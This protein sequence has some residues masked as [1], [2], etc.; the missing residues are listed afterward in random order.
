MMAATAAVL[1]LLWTTVTAQRDCSHVPH[2]VRLAIG[3]DDTMTVSFAS[4]WSDQ[5]AAP[6]GGVV[7]GTQLFVEQ[8]SPRSY[9]FT[10]LY[11]GEEPDPYASAYYHH[12]T[13][14][15]LDPDTEY[16][17]RP[18]FAATREE[19]TA[20]VDSGVMG[21]LEKEREKE[22][23]EN[24][25]ENS[26]HRSLFDQHGYNSK[27]QACPAAN[28]FRTF[29]TAPASIAAT[30]GVLGDIG[31]TKTAEQTLA[32]LVGSDLDFLLFAGDLCYC[33]GYAPFWDIFLDLMDDYPIGV[34]FMTVPGNHDIDKTEEGTEIFL[35]Y[36]HRFRMPQ[37]RPAELGVGP[38][39]EIDRN[40]VPYPLP[41]EWGNSYYSF[42]Y[43]G[44]FN[45]MLNVYAAM[46]P[47]SQQY[48]WLKT[49]LKKVNRTETPWLLVTMHVPLYNTFR[50]H[51]HDEQIL[52]ARKHLKP[53][54]ER[55]H[56]NVVF[57]GHLH[58]YQRTHALVH[59]A[60]NATGPMYITVG[61]GG[62]RESK[63][64]FWREEPEEWV[65]VRDSTFYGFGIL[66]IL[67]A[68]TAQWEW[69]HTGQEEE[70]P[71]NTVWNSSTTLP[72]GPSR[73]RL[74]LYNHA[75]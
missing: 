29:R 68:K 59:G 55:Y 15:G 44:T 30:I 31:R 38:V 1:L 70:H 64:D 32:R 62:G 37:V 17:Y 4:T 72:K 28:E 20:L 23:M 18:V 26:Q 27:S 57:S 40:E 16:S 5:K 24:D 3:H 53:L 12:V 43:A 45:I 52:V 69:I 34:P 22:E 63:L 14:D 51:R 66:R 41:Y 48:K 36:E 58:A 7:I 13:V 42:R 47:G 49:E 9:N 35:A 56:V 60:P 65:A 10:H 21:A 67:D 75:V 54:F 61:D 50:I 19:L 73:D 71:V 46:H 6:I 33:Y 11:Y 74:V 2:H 39:E 25:L 8:E